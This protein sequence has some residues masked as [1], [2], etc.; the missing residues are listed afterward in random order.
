MTVFVG[1]EEAAINEIWTRYDTRRAGNLDRKAIRQLLADYLHEVNRAIP[2]LVGNAFRK[3][4]RG[5]SGLS[6][7]G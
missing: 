3:R 5:A 6:F 2:Q 7:L 4:E 1:A